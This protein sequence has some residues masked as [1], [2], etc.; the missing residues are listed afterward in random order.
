MNGIEYRTM[1]PGEE[2]KVCEFANAVFIEF[3]SPIYSEEGTRE[4]Q[5]T[6]DPEVLKKDGATHGH[7]VFLALF[8]GVIA[9]VLKTKENNHI[10]WFFVE[11]NHQGQGIG[12]GLMEYAISHILKKSP[13]TR[14]VTVN[15]SPNS[16][17]A[18]E[19]LGFT[20]S[21]HESVVNGIRFT[22]FKRHIVD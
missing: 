20:A 9:G 8:K 2:E 19:S 13:N 14:E 6:T 22:P 17:T 10:S 18:Y 21:G 7:T 15:S 5:K 4:F 12:K 3:I 16:Y 11:S 1:K